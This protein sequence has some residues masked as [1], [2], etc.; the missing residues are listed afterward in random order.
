MAARCGA[1]TC[2]GAPTDADL[3]AATRAI[4]RL[5]DPALLAVEGRV[6]LYCSLR[7]VHGR[8]NAKMLKEHC[9]HNHELK[10]GATVEP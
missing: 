1:V 5:H 2:A 4:R 6:S 9:E 7:K 10:D 8:A 3:R